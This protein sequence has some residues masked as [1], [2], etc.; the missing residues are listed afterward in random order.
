MRT[1]LSDSLLNVSLYN[2]RRLV[3]EKYENIV[4]DDGV[5]PHLTPRLFTLTTRLF[6]SLHLIFTETLSPL[7]SSLRAG[8]LLVSAVAAR[9]ICRQRLELIRYHNLISRVELYG[10]QLIHSERAPSRMHSRGF[11]HSMSLAYKTSRILCG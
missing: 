9:L 2:L 11:L 4:G 7:T 8:M 10:R 6:R 5:G 3:D 1:S